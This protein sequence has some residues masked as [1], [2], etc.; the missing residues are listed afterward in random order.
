MNPEELDRLAQIIEEQQEKIDK[1]YASMEKMRKYFLWTLIITIVVFVL[2]LLG[3]IFVIP[4]F[5]QNY[6]TNLQ[7][8]AP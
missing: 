8:L 2:P 5:I 3:L 1:V 7:G 4:S 6:T